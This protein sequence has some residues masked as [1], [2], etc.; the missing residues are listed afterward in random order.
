MNKQVLKKILIF[1]GMFGLPAF[2]ILFLLQGEPHFYD[3]P[4]LGEHKV[5]TKIVDGKT[6]TD[7]IY[8]KVN[9]FTFTDENNVEVT[10]KDYQDKILLVNFMTADCPN[11]KMNVCPMNFHEFSRYIYDELLDNKGFEDIR[12]LSHFLSDGDTVEDMKLTYAHHNINKEKWR[13]VKGMENDIFNAKL[14]L[15]NSWERKDSIY[16]NEREAYIF[17]LLLDRERHVRG[18]YVTTLSVDISRITKDISLLLREERE[19]K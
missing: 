7:T 9:S 8:Y 1:A 2:F 4:Y 6:I 16:G 11:D 17:T 18:K 14:G 3:N 12:I 15:G 5:I 10:E 13:F 19:K